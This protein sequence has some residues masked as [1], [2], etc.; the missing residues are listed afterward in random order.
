[1]LKAQFKFFIYPDTQEKKRGQISAPFFN[2][3][4]ITYSY[5]LVPF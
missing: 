3:Y 2:K 1:M 4:Y 5:F